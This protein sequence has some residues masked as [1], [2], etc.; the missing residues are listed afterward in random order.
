MILLQI[1]YI[2]AGEGYVATEQDSIR[3]CSWLKR[4]GGWDLRVIQ[5]DN[6]RTVRIHDLKC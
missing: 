2:R 1:H 4:N 5:R 6:A 3:Y